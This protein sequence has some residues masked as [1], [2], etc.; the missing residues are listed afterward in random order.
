MALSLPASYPTLIEL[1]DIDTSGMDTGSAY[2]AIANCF[3]ELAD[4][5]DARGLIEPWSPSAT[6]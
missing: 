6:L 3:V 4:Q 2:S 5:A 1:F